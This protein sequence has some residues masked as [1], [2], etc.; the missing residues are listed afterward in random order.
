MST[1]P[2]TTRIVR[3]WLMTDE[4]ESATGV[5]EVALAEIETTPQRRATWWPV[6]RTPTMNKILGFGLAAAA[7][8][9]VVLIGSQV[10]GSNTGGVGADPTSTA[11]PEPTP[12]PVPSLAEPS[13][14]PEGELPEG[15]FVWSDPALETPPF[16]GGPLMTVTIP[17]S[18][19]IYDSALSGAPLI[20]GDE[21]QNLPEAAMLVMPTQAGIYVYGDPCRYESTTPDV[22]ATTVDEVTAA[23]AAQASRDASDPVDVTV[24]G[25]AGKSIIL[26]VPDD[27]VF[28]DCE[29]GE[30]A[31]FAV[32][33]E[34][35]PGRYSQGPGQVD[36]LWILDV[37]GAIVI[38]DAMYA[39][40]TPNAL[41]EE[42]RAIALSATFEAP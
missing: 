30:F 26:H 17:A 21:V 22:P 4:H 23:L 28:A 14:A 38:I 27:A 32:E 13:S 2:E 25:Y 11:T 42:M 16:D 19:W 7:V 15:P 39:P 37:D 24:G 10:I 3:S 34:T 35:G 40:T 5:V 33:G 8:V 1:D 41:I 6:R 12:T 29:E 36:E 20:K 9:A 31:M 18:G